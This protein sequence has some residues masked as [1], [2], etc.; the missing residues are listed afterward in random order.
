MADVP[1]NTRVYVHEPQGGAPV[2][3]PERRGEPF[4]GEQ[5]VGEEEPL[6]AKAVACREETRFA[7]NGVRPTERGELVDAFSARRVWTMRAKQV[8][9]QWL[10]IRREGDGDLSYSLSNTP[11]AATLQRL[12]WLKCQ[13]YFRADQP[14]QQVPDRLG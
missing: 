7:R 11:A 12:A 10:V 4:T 3:A 6:T 2:A 5:V 14:G 1:E 9:E 13:R 8:A